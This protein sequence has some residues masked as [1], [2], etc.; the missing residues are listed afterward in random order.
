[1]SATWRGIRGGEGRDYFD[2]PAWCVRRLLEYVTLPGGRW[3][4]PCVGVGSIVAEVQQLSGD[5]V[6][7][8][9]VDIAPRHCGIDLE[10]A[11]QADYLE[12]TPP[13]RY[14]VAI[15]N[16]PYRDAMEFVQ[17]MTS[18][19]DIAVCLLRLN[20]LASGARRDWL[21]A[22]RPE[23]F[24]LPNRPSF[25][26]GGTDSTEYAWMVWGRLGMAGQVHW[27]AATSSSERRAGQ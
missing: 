22:H 8:T 19:A 27:L 17:R 20:W 6:Q 5:A 15:T 11:V 21:D 23:V 1:M 9:A 13:H 10:L 3:L 25:T 14:E 12:W 16:P 26:G 18:M 7:W 24:V 4:E 2:T